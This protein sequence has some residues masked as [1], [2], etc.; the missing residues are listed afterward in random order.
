VNQVIPVLLYHSVSDEVG[1]DAHFAVSRAQFRAHLDAIEAS[2]RVT[3]CVSELAAGLRGDHE[4]PQRAVALTFDDGYADTYDAVSMLLDRGLRS[5]I[6]ITTGGVGAGDRLTPSDLVQLSRLS[7]VEIGAHA[8]RHRYLDELKHDEIAFEVEAS[9]VSLENLIQSPVES[10]AYPHGAYDAHVREAVITSGYRSA[11]AVKNAVSHTRDD[12]FAIAR[13]TVTT[14][15]SARRVE[16]VIEAVD[17]PMAWSRE[18]LRTYAYR[19]FRR[20]RSRLG[21]RREFPQFG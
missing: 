19:A 2:G 9:K 15:T 20:T 8:V 4:L 11:V 16:Q 3:L 1:S 6:Y 10:F 13:W 21:R 18:R 12:P 17:V 7:A 5:T 14:D